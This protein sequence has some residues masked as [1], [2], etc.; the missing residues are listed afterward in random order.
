VPWIMFLVV[1]AAQI[2]VGALAG[3]DR[4]V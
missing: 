4:V 1:Y 2:V 3:R